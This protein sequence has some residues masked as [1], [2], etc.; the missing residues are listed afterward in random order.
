MF[1]YCRT[2]FPPS[3]EYTRGLF[4]SR[5]RSVCPPATGHPHA[6]A[7]HADHDYTQH[8]EYSRPPVSSQQEQR[9]VKSFRGA[10]LE[11]R[12]AARRAR[13][14]SRISGIS[15]AT[16]HH[17]WVN[18]ES[19]W[20][21]RSKPCVFSLSWAQRGCLMGHLRG[22]WLMSNHQC[23]HVRA[24]YLLAE[25]FATLQ[26][27]TSGPTPLRRI[28]TELVRHPPKVSQG[29]IRRVSPRTSRPARVSCG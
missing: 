18:C 2:G 13:N 10:S 22:P 11:P 15:Y 25:L 9:V 1:A 14:G 28:F 4:V 21:E 16:R 8:P 29:Y 20:I 26:S 19:P 3:G 6:H 24:K 7:S 5:E 27:K 23:E 12:Q 17:L